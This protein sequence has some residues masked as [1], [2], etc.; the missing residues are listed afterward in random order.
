[1]RPSVIVAAFVAFACAEPTASHIQPLG[2]SWMEWTAQ[3]QEGQPLRVLIVGDQG[4]SGEY[5]RH[6]E[7]DQSNR[8]IVFNPYAI[9]PDE[10][11]NL[12]IVPELF[13]DAIDVSDLRAGTYQLKS[14]DQVFGEVV[15]TSDPP[16][17]P[18][19]VG[20]G[21]AQFVR[22][23][24]G[25]FRLRPA[26]TYFAHMLPLEDQADTTASWSMAFVTGHIIEVATPVC[27]VS[28][29]FH[30]VSLK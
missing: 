25:C 30:L 13:T 19:L 1:M 2:A 5:V 28:T 10:P 24:D 29:V 27:R 8:A 7:V 26:M 3:V 6:Y 12:G 4:C 17:A 15:V 14:R 9:V 16:D 11:C 18:P 21:S 23:N 22:D 20:A